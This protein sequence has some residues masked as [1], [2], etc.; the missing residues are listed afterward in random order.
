MPTGEILF[1]IHKRICK[2]LIHTQKERERERE[3][4]IFDLCSFNPCFRQTSLGLNEDMMLL[5]ILDMNISVLL[6]M[7]MLAEKSSK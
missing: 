2:L 7:N 3:L 5:K 1:L 4:P 6:I